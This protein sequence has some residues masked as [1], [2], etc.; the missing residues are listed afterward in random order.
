MSEQ[1]TCLGS[2]VCGKPNDDISPQDGELRCSSC[3]QLYDSSY[4]ICPN[5]ERKVVESIAEDAL[6][7]HSLATAR[8]TIGELKAELQ[9]IQQSIISACERTGCKSFNA[10]GLADEVLELRDELAKTQ[11]ANEELCN[12]IVEAKA[13]LTKLRNP[14]PVDFSFTD[15]PDCCAEIKMK[16][17][18]EIHE[19][20]NIMKYT[21]EGLARLQ[22]V[23]EGLQARVEEFTGDGN[24]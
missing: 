6:M 20:N 15:Q 16:L 12:T 11:T 3:N 19:I 24:E 23:V 4:I 7:P 21:D 13:E 9:S 18:D 1:C 22:K 10:S 8:T 17:I 14:L 2:H 5:C